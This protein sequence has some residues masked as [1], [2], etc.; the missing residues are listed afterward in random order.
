[1][2]KIKC[3]NGHFFNADKFPLCPVCGAKSA[4]L[5]ERNAIPKT[6]DGI[7][8]TT[9]LL[10]DIELDNAVPVTE[11]PSRKADGLV[12]TEALIEPEDGSSCNRPATKGQS[13]EAVSPVVQIQQAPVVSEVPKQSP[14][15][16]AVAGTGSKNIS[17]LP[18]TVSYYDM[19]DAEPPVGWAVCIKGPY[20]GRAFECKVG[21]NRFGRT[22]DYEICLLEDSA[23]T[24]ESHAIII[25]E[26]AKKQFYLQAGASDGLAYLNGNLLF[27]HE[28]L[29]P[30]DKIALGGSEF[31]FLPLCG[32]QFTWDEYMMKG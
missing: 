19:D 26:P 5:L 12:P 25:Y 21:R 4:G 20:L 13:A 16:R 18:K 14:L 7:S 10:S 17:A 32:E 11:C 29:H 22:P 8:K 9:P 30:Y 23:V 6:A 31:V 1:M 15:G 27:A 28:E 24:R 2:N 3:V